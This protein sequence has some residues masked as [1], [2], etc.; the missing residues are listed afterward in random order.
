MNK[1]LDC[2]WYLVLGSWFV[3]LRT[4]IEVLRGSCSVRNWM[5]FFQCSR[6]LVRHS[7]LRVTQLGFLGRS[8][9]FVLF[10]SH[11]LLS[12]AICQEPSTKIQ[13][14]TA[15]QPFERPQ[16]GIFPPLEKSKYYRG[17]LVFVDHAN[18]RGSIRVQGP[19]TFFRNSPQPFALLP[20]G[21]VRYCGG[22]ADLRDIPIGT[23][24]HARAFLPPDPKISSVPVIQ[25][26]TAERPSENHIILLEDEPSFC[27]REGKVWKLKEV[28]V[29]KNGAILFASREDVEGG[30]NKSNEEKMTFDSATR[31]WRGNECL[32]LEDL[33]AQGVWPAAGKK[34]L[35]GQPVQLGIVWHPTPESVFNQFH[36]ADIWLDD[37]SL[38]RASQRQTESNKSL[39]RSYWTPAWVEQVEYGK[40][41]RATVT[42][43]LFGGMDQSLYDD[44]KKGTQGLMAGSENTLKHTAG[45]YGPDHM[46]AGG[47]ITDVT[48]LPGKPPLGSSGIVIRFDTDLAIEAIRPHRVVRVRPASWPQ[49]A[50]P[51]EEYLNDG[52]SDHE[53][54]F[55]T[56]AIFPKY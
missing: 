11:A 7:S 35:D 25:N 33:I 34:S 44:F 32:V 6:C 8:L 49:V 3:V 4:W 47:T 10:G 54:R 29:R 39:L 40:F 48:V 52:G 26:G 56:P 37:V 38:K 51:R 13:D 5:F 31:I 55:P 36:V 20:Y 30:G 23:M 15:E 12:P 21:M 14:Q 28:D 43:T 41:G 27:M 19:G 53:D 42:A 1:L 22:P 2:C 9:L 50:V 18:R 24:L 45:A 16:S 17:E 46:A